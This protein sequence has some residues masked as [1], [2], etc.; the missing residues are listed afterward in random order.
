M[1]DLFEQALKIMVDLQENLLGP[2]FLFREVKDQNSVP[3]ILWKMD[4]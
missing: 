2:K 1:F 4:F 3:R